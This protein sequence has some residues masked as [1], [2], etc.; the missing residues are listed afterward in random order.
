[1]NNETQLRDLKDK[2][3]KFNHNHLLEIAVKEREEI[4]IQLL[5]MGPSL[6]RVSRYAALVKL[7]EDLEATH[8]EDKMLDINVKI[9]GDILDGKMDAPPKN[10]N[11]INVLNVLL[12]EKPSLAP[13]ADPDAPDDNDQKPTMK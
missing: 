5:N 10:S 8:S 11:E 13:A 3:I 2:L 6:Q 9:L 12:E 4:K 7:V 1:M